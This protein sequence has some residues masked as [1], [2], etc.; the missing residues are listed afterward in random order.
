ME[1]IKC[2]E[3]NKKQKNDEIN[4]FIN[5][6]TNKNDIQKINKYDKQNIINN[7]QNT[8]LKDTFGG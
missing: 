5:T 8:I 4:R 3:N 7:I 2:Y 6:S 1:N